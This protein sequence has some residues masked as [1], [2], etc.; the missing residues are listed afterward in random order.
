MFIYLYT[1]I[2]ISITKYIYVYINIYRLLYIVCILHCMC[3]YIYHC[4]I[5]CIYSFL[6]Q[7]ISLWQSL[8]IAK[9]PAPD[10]RSCGISKQQSCNCLTD[11]LQPIIHVC[12]SAD[13]THNMCAFL[14]RL[15]SDHDN[16]VHV[17]FSRLVSIH[18]YIYTQYFQIVQT[19]ENIIVC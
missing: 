10:N 13:K 6:Y 12:F 8:F 15:N 19:T 1:Y 17:H 9:L 7:I 4:F 3:I 16:V 11:L 18:T 14:Y 5:V 2:Y